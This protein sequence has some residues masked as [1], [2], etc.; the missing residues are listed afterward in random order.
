MCFFHLFSINV[1]FGSTSKD[2]QRVTLLQWIWLTAIESFVYLGLAACIVVRLLFFT[3]PEQFNFVLYF[4]CAPLMWQIFLF[5]A[6]PIFFDILPG[7]LPCQ[8]RV[9]TKNPRY[10]P[11]DKMFAD[12]YRTNIPNAKLVKSIKVGSSVKLGINSSRATSDASETIY[13][14]RTYDR[15]TKESV[16][17]GQSPSQ[18]QSQSVSVTESSSHLS[19][20]SDNAKIV[21][22]EKVAAEEIV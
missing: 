19:V 12:K 6:G 9:D 5:W 18:S 4:G 22:T 3:S 1:S 20:P 8:Q 17:Y 11:D 21:T 14:S 16:S 10:D 7:M 2:N 15:S 13:T